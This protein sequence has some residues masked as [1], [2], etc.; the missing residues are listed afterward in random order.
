MYTFPSR[1]IRMY[2]RRLPIAQIAF[3]TI[4][5]FFT[6]AT[7]VF[8]QHTATPQADAKPVTKKIAKQT[9]IKQNKLTPTPSL[10]SHKNHLSLTPTPT[11]QK[12][13]GG[14]NL[15]ITAN[16][17]LFPT[18]S[19]SPTSISVAPTTPPAIT[20]GSGS[21]IDQVNAYRASQ[22]L[23]PVQVS[24]ETCNFASTRA[25]EITTNFSHDGF[26]SRLSGGTLPYAHWTA[27]TENIAETA[28][29]QSVVQLWINSP[30]HAANMR[31]DTPYV[32]IQQNGNYYAYEGMKP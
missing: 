20:S 8:A 11:I 25:Q 17:T 6:A 15:Q 1:K 28:N 12:G 3:V 18:S 22:G 29:P 13:L 21:L 26:N 19:I 16:P 14:T 10:V 2:T 24:T 23:G 32:C 31:A 4:G 9:N 5:I 30:E 7:L 27:V